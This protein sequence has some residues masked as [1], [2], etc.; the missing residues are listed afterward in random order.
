LINT[1]NFSIIIPAY[2][3]ENAIESII[4][5]CFEAK[6]NIISKTD[7]NDIEIIVVSDGSTDATAEIAKK[8]VPQIKLIAYPDNR[9]YGRAIKIGFESAIGDIVSFLDADGTCEPSY[10]ADMILKLKKENADICIGSRM[11]PNSKMPIVRKVGNIFFRFLINLI[12]K[13]DISDAASGMRI[14]K[15]E[16]LPCIYP[17]PDGLHFT[18][19]MS[20][21]AVMD[22]ELKIVEID[23]AYKERQGK[24]KLSVVK[25]GFRFL[26]IIITTA[27]TYKP[28]QVLTPL[29]LI[30]FIISFL[31]GIA[32][33]TSYLVK[34]EFGYINQIYY[35]FGTIVFGLSGIILLGIASFVDKTI[36]SLHKN[37][38]RYKS[39]RIRR[40]LPFRTLWIISLALLLGGIL[41]NFQLLISLRTIHSISMG[42]KYVFVSSFLVLLGITCFIIGVADYI[43]NLA[44]KRLQ[45]LYYKKT[46]KKSL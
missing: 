32:L 37:F 10:F 44:S 41:L 15:K 16:K 39:Y 42:W 43:L 11:G 19:G 20:S 12:A 27:L 45:F 24:S 2:N 34:N 17:L 21:K 26:K 14:I 13:S 4:K 36:A 38:E 25:D 3:E 28:L 29:S 35:L 22:P 33:A 23:M 18:P 30:L 46:E 9:G 31:F 1:K 7:I 6:E 8:F 5:R 40:F